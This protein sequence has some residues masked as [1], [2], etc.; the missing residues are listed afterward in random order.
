M[1]DE[2]V[3]AAALA[4]PDAQPMTQEQLARMVRRPHVDIIRRS[5][6]FTQEEFAFKFGIPL[7]TLKSWEDRSVVPDRVGLALLAV[8]VAD[9]DAVERAVHRQGGD[10]AKSAAE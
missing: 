8:I 7:A 1:S 10:P 4:D 6:G 2:E 3:E 5:F 9:P